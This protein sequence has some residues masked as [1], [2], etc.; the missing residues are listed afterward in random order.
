M[1]NLIQGIR[2][3]LI[4]SIIIIAVTAAALWYLINPKDIG[5]SRKNYMMKFVFFF[6]LTVLS[7]GMLFGPEMGIGLSF[8]EMNTHKGVGK[9]IN[10]LFLVVSFGLMA[11]QLPPWKGR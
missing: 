11:N 1:E 3:K 2:M 9:F 6:T 8:F 10:G 7:A 4:V 5:S